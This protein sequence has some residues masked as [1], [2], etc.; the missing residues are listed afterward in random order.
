MKARCDFVSNSSSSSFILNNSPIFEHFKITKEELNNAIIDLLGKD[1]VNE[2]KSNCRKSRME[3]PECED[4]IEAKYGIESGYGPYWIYDLSIESDR[5]EAL[6][7]F[8]SL[9][10][11]W[12]CHSTLSHFNDV[13]FT[14]VKNALAHY[15]RVCK[16][17]AEIY[18]LRN[19]WDGI[20]R[21]EKEAKGLE[22]WI[23]TDE[24]QPDGCYGYRS[25]A[26]D[27]VGKLLFDIRKRCGI[28]TNKEVLEQEC[29]KFFVHFD[30]N[31]LWSLNGSNISGKN[32]EVYENPKSD[33]EKKHNE[34]VKSSIYE[35][36]SY[37]KERVFEILWNYWVK[38]ALI[39]PNDEEFLKAYYPMSEYQR[40][41]KEDEPAKYDYV[42]FDT[43]N[44]K[45]LSYHDLVDEVLTFEGHEG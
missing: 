25:K 10:D 26:P 4:E 18:Q 21:S 39:N 3:Y 20:I 33:Y 2:Y 17:I 22:I 14:S 23:R 27:F 12:D 38:K 8:G 15:E 35:S 42:K 13:N 29:S 5:K 40:I 30:D 16:D 45:N 24:K 43:N 34:E 11:E 37:T 44:E 1:Y 7:R 36:E 28:M 32:E 31:V 6:D 41:M 9:L 19:C